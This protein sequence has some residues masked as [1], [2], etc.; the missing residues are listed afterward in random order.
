MLLRSCCFLNQALCYEGVAMC[1]V[2]YFGD[3]VRSYFIFLNCFV[4]RESLYC[5]VFWT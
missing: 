5:G 1:I 3:T 2:G 4:M